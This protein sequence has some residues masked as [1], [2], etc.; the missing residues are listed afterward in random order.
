MHVIYWPSALRARL[1]GSRGGTQDE[2]GKEK[3]EEEEEDK[4][5]VLWVE[6]DE[7]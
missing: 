7:K 1:V 2:E 4:K 3:H 6:E 5:R